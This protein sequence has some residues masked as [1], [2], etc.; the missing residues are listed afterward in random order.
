MKK[1]TV[2]SGCY[3]EEENLEELF[4]RVS[5][6]MNRFTAYTWDFIVIDNCSTDRSPE[7]L[8]KLAAT[9]PFFKVIFNA[10]NFGHIR[11]PYHGMLQARSDAMIYLASDLQDPPEHIA[12]FIPLWEDGYKVV[13]G[14]KNESEESPLFFALRKAYYSA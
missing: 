13:A 10:R 7:I 6:V 11:S 2:V 9:H 4:R 14:I 5:E 12:D 3:N 1:I 8:R